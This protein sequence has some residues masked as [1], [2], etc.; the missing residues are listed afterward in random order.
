MF[1]NDKGGKEHILIQQLPKFTASLCPAGIQLE[2]TEE[3]RR[4]GTP[5]I[6]SFRGMR[7]LSAITMEQLN[8]DIRNHHSWRSLVVQATID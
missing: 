1:R 7:E 6:T 4:L 8:I 5:R 3:R 2:P